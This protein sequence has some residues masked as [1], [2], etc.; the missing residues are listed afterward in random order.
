MDNV[1][2]NDQVICKIEFIDASDNNKVLGT[3]NCD[4]SQ[5]C[6]NGYMFKFTYQE[7]IIKE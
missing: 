1:T 3:V 7:A 6:D 5:E 4:G 2:I